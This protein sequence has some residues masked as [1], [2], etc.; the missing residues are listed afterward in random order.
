MTGRG[1]PGS[2][3]SSGSQ[4]LSPQQQELVRRS[5]LVP[6][7]ARWLMSSAASLDYDE[8]VSAGHEELVRA[9]LRF[10]AS[11]GV[12]FD[13]YAFTSVRFAMLKRL[14]TEWR[15]RSARELLAAQAA[16]SALLEIETADGDVMTET[17][18]EAQGRLDAFSDGLAAAFVSGYLG[19]VERDHGEDAMIDMLSHARALSTLREILAALPAYR[20]VIELRDF[21]GHGWDDVA[22]LLDKSSAT[23]RRE[24]AQAMR[25]IGA[26]LRG[27]E[28]SAAE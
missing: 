13:Q 15:E 7:L 25:L 28:V 1:A 26:R 3:A 18:A 16:G 6:R 2:P 5:T 10:D 4:A 14:N 21:E 24:Y 22:A 23:V 12:P 11:L 9:A 27:S 8:L 19:A 20:R 17:P